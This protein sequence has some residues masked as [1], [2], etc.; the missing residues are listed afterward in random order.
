[1][2]AYAKLWLQRI[3]SCICIWKWTLPNMYYL[4][5]IYSWI[6]DGNKSIRKVDVHDVYLC[7]PPPREEKKRYEVSLTL[8]SNECQDQTLL[9]CFCMPYIVLEMT[10]QAEILWEGMLIL[11][12]FWAVR[13]CCYTSISCCG[14]ILHTSPKYWKLSTFQRRWGYTPQY[15]YLCDSVLQTSYYS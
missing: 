11:N 4:H 14:W 2:H 7:P 15:H 10:Q 8:R 3:S 12:E 1:M 9:M 5:N 6:N 13:L